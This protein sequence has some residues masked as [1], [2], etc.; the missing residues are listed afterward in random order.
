MPCAKNRVVDMK[1]WFVTYVYAALVLSGIYRETAALNNGV[2]RTPPS[3]TIDTDTS[4]YA[5]RILWL[6]KF[7]ILL[8][9]ISGLGG[10]GE[11][12]VQH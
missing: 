11:I 2:A 3:E 9:C 4:T 7:N 1:G 6:T 8:H 12:R 10:L 5:I